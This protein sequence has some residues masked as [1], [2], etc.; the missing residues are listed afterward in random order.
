MTE[1]GGVNFKDMA[2]TLRRRRHA[3]LIA[4]FDE[5]MGRL[6][7]GEN[8]TARELRLLE[9]HLG[10]DN[11]FEEY[12]RHHPVALGF[13]LGAGTLG[14]GALIGVIIGIVSRYYI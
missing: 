13:L 12:A 2:H 11:S 9:Y 5:V 8:V 6:E 3:L 4:Q 14:F 7:R 1:H 10:A